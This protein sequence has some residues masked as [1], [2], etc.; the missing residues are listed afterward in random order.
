MDYPVSFD[1]AQ[2]PVAPNLRKHY[3]YRLKTGAAYMARQSVVLTGL[4]RSCAEIIETTIA[5]M[6]YTGR[7]FQQYQILIY[8]NDSD[9]DTLALLRKAARRNR[10]ITI[11]SEQRCDPPSVTTRCLA[12]VTRMAYYRNCL[13][14]HILAHWP[15]YPYVLMIDTDL[16]GGWSYDGLRNTFGYA[17]AWDGVGSNGILYRSYQGQANYPL[18]YDAWT[19]RF[20]GSDT[21]HSAARINPMRWSRGL[22]LIPFNSVFGGLAA[23]RMEAM[24]QAEYDGS[25]VC[26]V[27]FHRRMR[28]AGLDRIYLN[29]SQIVC[30]N[31]P[32]A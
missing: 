22:P 3:E 32:A 21:P 28:E 26:H 2:F 27:P 4:A 20:K 24:R 13:R 7:L 1:E 10:R 29:P 16:L 8:E 17:E 5:R 9:D 30:Y 11:L 19:L 15:D 12:R 31:Y 25:D 23:Y 14:E 18:Q 6:E